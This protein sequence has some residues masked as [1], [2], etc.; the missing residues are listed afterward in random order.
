[1]DYFGGLS[2]EVSRLGVV[3]YVGSPAPLTEKRRRPFSVEG[4]VL[5]LFMHEQEQRPGRQGLE[6]GAAWRMRAALQELEKLPG[7]QGL[8]AGAE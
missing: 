7:R 6:A 3:D 2:C 5:V 8:K 4:W 1:M